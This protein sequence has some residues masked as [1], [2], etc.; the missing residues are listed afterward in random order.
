VKANPEQLPQA[1]I[2]I[3]GDGTITA[4]VDGEMFLAGPIDRDLIGHVT[5]SV[6]EQHGGPIWVEI[7]EPDGTSRTDIVT[8]PRR[9][10]PAHA[11]PQSRADRPTMK[12]GPELL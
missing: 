1:V 3:G 8:P 7:R 10:P 2:T 9:V 11:H 4:T 12:S 6:A 5:A